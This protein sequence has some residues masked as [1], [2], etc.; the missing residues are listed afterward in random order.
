ME[1]RRFRPADADSLAALFNRSHYWASAQGASLS[2]AQ[3]LEVFAERMMDPIYV[4]VS[5]G[6]VYGSMAFSRST[7]RRVGRPLERFAGLY[8]IDYKYRNSMLGG[9]LFRDAFQDLV[10]NTD[11]RTIRLEV[12]PTNAQALPAYLRAGFRSEPGA[13]ADE[14]AYIEMVSHLPGLIADMRAANNQLPVE[15][16]APK[17]NI[18]MM[19]TRRAAAFDSGV[20]MVG[21]RPRVRYPLESGGIKFTADLDLRTGRL[22]DLVVEKNAAG[23]VFPTPGRPEDDPVA[24]LLA[25]QE[26]GHGGLSATFSSDGTLRLQRGDQPVLLERWPVLRGVDPP[27]VRRGDES[28]SVRFERTAATWR[29]ADAAGR[30]RRSIS[31]VAAGEETSS[32]IVETTAS[33]ASSPLIVTPLCTMRVCEHALRLGREW[34]GGPALLGIWPKKY[35]NFEAAFDDPALAAAS[36]SAWC[37]AELGLIATWSGATARFESRTLPQLIGQGPGATVTYRIDLVDPAQCRPETA[38]PAFAL[39][40]DSDQT[41]PDQSP[42]SPSKC[43]PSAALRSGTFRGPRETENSAHSAK[44]QTS[45]GSEPL[46]RA[47]APAPERPSAD[48]AWRRQDRDACRLA[49]TSDRHELEIA[50]EV[51]LIEWR[52]DHSPV[53]SGP[54]PAHA[55]QG[56][57]TARRVGLWCAGIARRSGEDQGVEWVEDRAGLPF[58]PAAGV[59]GSWS[60][61]PTGERRLSVSAGLAEPSS[62]Q[63]LAIMVAPNASPNTPLIIRLGERVWR[64]E[65]RPY[66]WRGAVDAIAVPL[67]N[68][69]TLVVSPTRQLVRPEVFLKHVSNSLLLT[70]LSAGDAPAPAIWRLDVEPS[71][72]A[73][74]ET[75]RLPLGAEEEFGALDLPNYPN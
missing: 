46:S 58:S 5:D 15:A 39:L 2:G 61:S 72:S 38:L 64:L 49:L 31:F 62:D 14:D 37:D 59:A 41:D 1:V 29:A 65:Q 4:G 68:G 32:V 69:Q 8:V 35:T 50:T 57:L 26:L 43:P 27:A 45:S 34:V 48:R 44:S 3:L 33:P 74:I 6:Q 70:L 28:K 20:T 36:A 13:R 24:Q 16:L 66:D 52:L 10:T 12:R 60:V 53:L 17:M 25:R 56:A 22:V 11:I 75:I 73:A 21:G 42:R 63:D 40:P 55:A 9:Q 30:I 47:A 71:T 54:F 18:R 67:S 7:G 23:L 19:L 51:G